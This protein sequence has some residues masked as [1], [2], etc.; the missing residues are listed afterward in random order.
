MVKTY[1][2]IY[3]DM[4]RELRACGHE[5]ADR[6]AREIICFVT[7]KTREQLLADRQL[8]VGD[9]VIQ[10]VE[11]LKERCLAGEPL[12]YII[13]EWSF[14]GLDL[15][16][17]EAV[18]IPRMDTETVVTEVIRY[19]KPLGKARLLD[20]C[21][22]SGCIGLAVASRCPAVSVLGVELSEEAQRVN[23]QNI[24]RNGLSLRV[25]CASGDVRQPPEANMGVFDCI[26]CNP[27]YIPTKDCE[28]LDISVRE[29]EPRMALDGGADGLDFY[30]AVTANWTGV[31]RPDGRLFFEV[32]I[33]QAESV[34]EL[35]RQAGFT[36][37]AFTE[38]SGG[39]PRVV[40]GRLARR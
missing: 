29:H 7:G 36:D 22:G 37:L 39:I 24:R 21:S 16:V 23:R 26:V 28:T 11:K 34:A 3:L 20:L 12:A 31:L 27:P 18:L 40:S 38:D 17:D 8:Y 32:G 5:A 1:N 14:Y 33:G 15:D 6:E 2:D 10:A 13:G 9:A 35:M 19:L 4:R 30:R 25:I